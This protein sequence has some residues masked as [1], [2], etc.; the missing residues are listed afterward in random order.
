VSTLDI[1]LLIPLLTAAAF[2]LYSLRRRETKL[3][4][5]RLDFLREKD[6]PP[7]V[8][9]K[10]PWGELARIETRVAAGGVLL[11]VLAVFMINLPWWVMPLQLVVVCPLAWMLVRR[12]RLSR[13]R[14]K[15][16][17]RFPEAVDGLTRAVQAGV[18]LERALASLGDIFTGEMA[19]R[20]RKLVRQ[21]E[22]GV[23]FREALQNFSASL[24]L[25]DVDFFCAV[26]AV[27]RET[28][29][30][31]SPMLISLSKTLSERRNVAR[32]L[33]G[34]TAESRSAATVLSLLPIF[35][36][37]LQA[38][39]NPSQLRFLLSDPVGRTVVAYCV[40]S[41]VAGLVVIRRM[42][43]LTVE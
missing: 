9:D 17:E 26:L 41:M 24:N 30:P 40:C 6:P 22:I 20:F 10:I 32:K 27:N 14:K 7:P 11:S 16:A 18:P 1:L 31:L 34:L 12:Y 37:G 39:L 35:I 15:F 2:A 4:Y 28:G 13:F 19:E 8:L 36:I 23:P 43:R 42:S 3:L 33:Q 38:F 25:A 21:M 29:S 5:A